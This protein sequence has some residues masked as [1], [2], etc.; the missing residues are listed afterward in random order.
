ML[1]AFWKH[2]EQEYFNAEI[3]VK[4]ILILFL[5]SL[6]SNSFITEQSLY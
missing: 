2:M 3:Q 4:S 6:K 1:L 5:A